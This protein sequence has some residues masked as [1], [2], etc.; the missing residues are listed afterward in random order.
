MPELVEPTTAVHAS[1]LQAVK[2]YEAEGR[3]G[4]GDD[5]M[6]GHDMRRY[7]DSWQDPAV[8]ATYVERCRADAR[9]DTERPAGFVPTTIL[10]W[11]DHGED[12]ASATYLGRLNIRHRLTPRLLDHG[13]LIGYDVRPSARRRGHA[14]A[15]LRA[16][17]P[18]A[19][20][21]G[22]D[23]VLL[24]CDVDNVASRKVIE[25]CGGVYEDQRGVKLRYWIPTGPT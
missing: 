23:P 10:W 16:A 20:R 11:V 21:L 17:L 13:G 24:T 4:P 15:M 3:G 6:Q 19:Y 1:F 25:A 2:E 12:G 14:T 7:G 18:L 5:S 8:F 9:E 22:L